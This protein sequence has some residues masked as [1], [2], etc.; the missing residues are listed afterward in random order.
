ML[1][2]RLRCEPTTRWLK[3]IGSWPIARVDNKRDKTLRL[4]AVPNIHGH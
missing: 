1:S 3:N 2:F 4:A